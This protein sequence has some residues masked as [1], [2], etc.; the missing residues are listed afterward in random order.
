MSGHGDGI[1][2]W[3]HVGGFVFGALAALA[4]SYSGLEHRA[5]KAIEKKVSWTADPEISEAS[6]LIENGKLD[7]ARM[8]LNT[9]LA[10]KPDSL[11]AWSLLRIVQLAEKRNPPLP[12]SESQGVYAKF[13]SGDVR[14]GLAGLRGVSQ[15]G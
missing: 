14:S 3:A 11:G 2:H 8:V 12:R 1:A 7:Q 4:L 9:Y 15:S 6:D 10:G 5:N 13:A